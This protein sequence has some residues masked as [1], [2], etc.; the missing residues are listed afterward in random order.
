MY[1]SKRCRKI[2]GYLKGKIQF[3][4]PEILGV[5]SKVSKLTIYPPE[6]SKNGN[7]NLPLKFYIKIDGN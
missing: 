6:V 5:N 7:L 4:P 3:T 1:F 2:C